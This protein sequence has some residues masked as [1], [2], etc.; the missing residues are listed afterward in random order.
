MLHNAMCNSNDYMGG[1]S[2][3]GFITEMPTQC[4]EDS[5]D[6]LHKQVA[7]KWLTLFLAP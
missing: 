4:Q 5:V 2:L 3:T 6:C 1:G 7:Y